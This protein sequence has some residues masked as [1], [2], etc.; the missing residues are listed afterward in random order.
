MKASTRTGKATAGR[1]ASK[2]ERTL[3]G[4][5]LPGCI[6]SAVIVLGDKWTPLLIHALAKEPLR[7]CHLQAAV[8]GVNPR[9]LSSRLAFLEAEGILTKTTY[10]AIPPHTEY[11]LTAKGSDLLP[12]IVAM[13][14]WSAK[15]GEAGPPKD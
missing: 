2:R 6:H 11:R 15:Y 12:I 13:G 7:F 1:A 14:E 5:A 4:S 8:G 9:T 10:S 3:E